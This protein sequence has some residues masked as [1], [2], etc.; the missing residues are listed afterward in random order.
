V[1]LNHRKGILGQGRDRAT[2]ASRTEETGSPVH[3]TN[4]LV[5]LFCGCCLFGQS[6]NV[7]VTGNA[8]STAHWQDY[9]SAI[10]PNLTWS[11]FCLYVDED[12]NDGDGFFLC[13]FVTAGNFGEVSR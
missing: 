13:Q 7:R 8:G 12:P 6:G 5:F 10:P 3:R 1:P 11:D 4:T 2:A 9:N